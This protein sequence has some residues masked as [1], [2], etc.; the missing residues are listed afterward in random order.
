MGAIDDEKIV[1]SEGLPFSFMVDLMREISDV[2]SIYGENFVYHIERVLNE[3]FEEINSQYKHNY[4]D[5]LQ[6]N[7]IKTKEKQEEKWS[8]YIS[9]P[10]PF[11]LWLMI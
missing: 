2:I 11:T 5:L 9:N 7:L 10:Y 1:E 4:I 3:E 6:E 8:S